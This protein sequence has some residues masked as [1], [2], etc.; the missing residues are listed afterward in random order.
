MQIWTLQCNVATY[1]GES[2]ARKICVPANRPEMALMTPVEFISVR[3]TKC[4][5]LINNG[6]DL[7]ILHTHTH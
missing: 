6:I 7:H 3:P 2:S 5:M 1:V 4:R